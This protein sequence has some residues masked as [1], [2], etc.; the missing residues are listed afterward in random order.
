MNLLDAVKTCFNKYATVSGRAARS[1]F[2]FWV[3]FVFL[4]SLILGIIDGILFG[5][6]DAAGQS[7]GSGPLG[8]VFSLATLIPYICVGA[9]RMHDVNRSGWWILINLIPII[10]WIV[11]IVWAATKGTTG[12]NRYGPDPLA[13]ATI[14]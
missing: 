13:T 11:F 6:V 1:E 10:G 5:V 12:D 8:L 14:G 2:W 4:G 9:R 3:L 7:K